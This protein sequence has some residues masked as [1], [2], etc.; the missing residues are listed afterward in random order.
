MTEGLRSDLEKGLGGSY[1]IAPY[2]AITK[3]YKKTRPQL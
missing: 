3:A 2:G 1:S